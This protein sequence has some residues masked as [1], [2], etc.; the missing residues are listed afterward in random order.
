[1]ALSAAQFAS[2]SDMVNWCH[3]L[4]GEQGRF[5]ALKGQRPDDEITALPAGF[6][7]E[8]IVRLSVPRLDGE[9]HLVILKANRT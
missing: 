2:L 9:R 7:V 4:P 8:E 5:Y 3:H 6:A 1:M